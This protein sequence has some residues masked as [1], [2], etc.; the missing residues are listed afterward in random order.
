MKRIINILC[1]GFCL[2]LL[3]TNELLCQANEANEEVVS[4]S[5]REE[6]QRYVGY[7]TLLFRYLSLPYDV[8]VNIN[9]R[10]TG[11]LDIGFLLLM[12]LP[13]LLMVKFKSRWWLVVGIILASTLMLVVSTSNS[14]IYNKQLQQVEENKDGDAHYMIDN[15]NSLLERINRGTY[16]FNNTLYSPLKTLSKQIS[17]PKDRITYPLVLFITVL[18]FSLILYLGKG[19]DKA[20]FTVAALFYLFTF[21]WFILSP[22]I[23]WYG[24]LGIGLGFMTLLAMGQSLDGSK[25]KFEQGIKYSLYG[26]CSVWIIICV[27]YRMSNINPGSPLQ[28]MGKTMLNPV[29]MQLFAGDISMDETLDSFYPGTSQV[30]KRI[31]RDKRSLVYRVGTSFSYFIDN[32]HERIFFDNQ[33]HF[34]NNLTKEFPDKRNLATAL[35]KSNFR[36]LL[37]DLNTPTLDNTPE[38]SLIKKYEKMI[39]F[40]YQNPRVRLLATNR[41]V[42]KDGDGSQNT[43]R[44][45]DMFGS[46]ILSNGTF[47]IYEI[48]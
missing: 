16:N 22:G 2:L 45:Y 11:F 32:N 26:M 18:F 12:F 15:S 28:L 5:K 20:K 40:V 25:Q 46:Q 19:L 23:T 48:L 27:I 10:G 7:E 34:F 17:G 24:F 33:L 31:N 14:F 47:A 4:N 1:F 8:T 30:I 35:K 3:E 41:T 37:I 29:Y 43:Q 42:T 9:E 6:I 38:Q 39:N 44:Y 36:Y 13:I 21:Y